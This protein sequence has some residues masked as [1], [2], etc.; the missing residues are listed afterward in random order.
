M[1]VRKPLTIA[2]VDDD[3]EQRRL[4]RGALEDA[5]YSVV[6][7][8]DGA[9]A[10]ELARSRPLDAMALDVRMP[11]LSG[12]EA[13]ER[14]KAERAEIVVVL[15]TAY[16]DVRDAVSAIKTGAHD[17]LEKPIDLD[18]LVIAFDEALGVARAGLPGAADAEAPLPK[19]VV[20]ESA[21]MR[22][23]FREALRVAPTDATVLIFGESGVGKE[24]VARHIHQ[25]SRRAGG[26][27]V[28]VNCAALPENLIE[29]ELFGHE[30]GAFTGAVSLTKGRFEEA[31]GGTLL[32][33]EIG[34]MPLALQPKLLRVLEER[35]VRRVGGGRD[36]PVD[37]RVI[38]ATN[39]PLE[40]DARE[41]RFREDL[42]YRLNVFA[43][44]IPPLRRRRE[45]ILPLADQF[46]VQQGLREKRF[47]PAA[48]RLLVEHAW[49]GNV[50]ELRNAVVR[51]AILSRGSLILPDDLPESVRSPRAPSDR[52]ANVLVGDMEEIQKRAILHALQESNGNKTQAAK[53]LG[54][55]RRNLIYK[56]R[57]YGM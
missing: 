20:A 29:S 41:G 35:R 17:Y 47:S 46:L 5:G 2:V 48:Q 34:E 18:E 27:F 42:L 3:P 40:D 54:I 9:Q 49:P 39:R 38:A 33:D 53:R 57:S 15:L 31:D 8:A 21:E 13:L 4:L 50:R 36:V 26:R 14:I 23:V 6:E 30:K 12:L 32:L 7:A 56:L 16:I 28:A 37:A 51:S 10:V 25:N 44:R 55:S 22:A 1:D 52:S 11:G 43:L 45:D 24:V 19:D